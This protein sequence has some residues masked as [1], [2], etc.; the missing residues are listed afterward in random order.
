MAGKPVADGTA[1]G[2][3]FRDSFAEFERGVLQDNIVLCDQKAG[4]LLAFAAAM[5]LV[6]LQG[7]DTR[8]APLSAAT[9]AVRGAFALGAIAFVVSCHFAL[10]TV[11]PRI[12]RGAD[13]HIYWESKVFKLSVERYVARFREMDVEAEAENRLRY[14]HKLAE[15]CRTKFRHFRRAMRL[16]QV[17]FVVLMLAYLG[18][19]L[20]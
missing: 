18:R 8:G 5:I 14:L 11:F 16:A 19:S 7:F 20:A 4:I 9:I 10:E 17:G 3:E 2:Q 15:I 1:D 13:D 12:R 6:C